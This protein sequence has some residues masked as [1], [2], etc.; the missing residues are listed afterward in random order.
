MQ[1]PR[2]RFLQ[3]AAGAAALPAARLAYADTYP[4]RPVHLVVG[5]AAGSA[6]D[7]NARLVGQW[8]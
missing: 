8:L 5:F 7:I 2:R 4:S 3:L 1:I 6:Y